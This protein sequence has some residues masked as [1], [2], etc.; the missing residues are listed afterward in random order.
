MDVGGCWVCWWVGLAK[1]LWMLRGRRLERMGS[2][3]GMTS[4]P[5]GVLGKA[6]ETQH[7]M[8]NSTSKVHWYMGRV[9]VWMMLASALWHPGCLSKACV[10]KVV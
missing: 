4:S 3:V 1:W 8:A 6:N 9:G 10:C 5:W 2:R 7:G